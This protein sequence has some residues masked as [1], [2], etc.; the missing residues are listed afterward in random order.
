MKNDPPYGCQKYDPDRLCRFD[1]RALDRKC[2]GCLRKTDV[3]FLVLMS[4]WVP[5]ISHHKDDEYHAAVV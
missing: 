3:E 5:G 1:R 2:D 4:L